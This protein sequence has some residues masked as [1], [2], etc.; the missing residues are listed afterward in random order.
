MLSITRKIDGS[1][2]GDMD[3]QLSA[4]D[5]EILKYAFASYSHVLPSRG[6]F[7][8]KQWADEIRTCYDESN[9][10]TAEVLRVIALAD[11]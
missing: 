2:R 7:T 8:G 5:H 3:K 6:L 11:A 4:A 10:H 9:P 1:T